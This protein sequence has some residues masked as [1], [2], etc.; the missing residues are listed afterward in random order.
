MVGGIQRAGEGKD[1]NRLKDRDITVNTN[2]HGPEQQMIR[3]SKALQCPEVRSPCSA[4]RAAD[5]PE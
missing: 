4:K 1:E 3:R 5:G 2:M